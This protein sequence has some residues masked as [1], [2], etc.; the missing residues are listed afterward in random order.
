MNLAAASSLVWG[1]Y[2]CCSQLLER[3][4]ALAIPSGRRKVSRLR[5]CLSCEHHADDASSR[6][7]KVQDV[8]EVVDMGAQAMM[9]QHGRHG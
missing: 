9:G 5:P 8:E 2:V 1:H 7:V 4:V 6:A 3:L